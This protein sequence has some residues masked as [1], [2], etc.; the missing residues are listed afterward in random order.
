MEYRP[1]HHKSLHITDNQN[2]KLNKSQDK[3]DTLEQ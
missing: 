2:R 3:G 1:Q